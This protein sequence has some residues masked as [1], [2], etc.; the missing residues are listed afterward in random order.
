M[1]RAAVAWV[2]YEQRLG[3]A[4]NFMGVPNDVCSHRYR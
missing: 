4:N 3:A 2:K 1:V